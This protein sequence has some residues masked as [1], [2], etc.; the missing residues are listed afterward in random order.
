MRHSTRGRG[1]CQRRSANDQGRTSVRPWSFVF[2]YSRL[3]VCQDYVLKK[4]ITEPRSSSLTMI[5]RNVI[6]CQG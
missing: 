1:G 6:R 2:H 5:S 3:A 4:S